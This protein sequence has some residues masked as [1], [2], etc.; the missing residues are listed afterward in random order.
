MGGAKVVHALGAWAAGAGCALHPE[1]CWG[2]GLTALHVA[3][4]LREPEEVAL[5]LTGL[6]PADSPEL[7]AAACCAHGEETPLGLACRMNKRSLLAALAV[8]GV[9]AAGAMLAALQLQD[10]RALQPVRVAAVE[11]GKAAAATKRLLATCAEEEGLQRDEWAKLMSHQPAVDCNCGAAPMDG[12]TASSVL[13]Q[14]PLAAAE[15]DAYS[16]AASAAPLLDSESPA[17]VLLLRTLS[18][19]CSACSSVVLSGKGAGKGKGGH[20]H[21]L[22]GGSTSD[23]EDESGEGEGEGDWGAPLAALH[24]AVASKD[25]A[26]FYLPYHG[27][28]TGELQL[29]GR[30]FKGGSPLWAFR[31]SAVERSFRTWHS[32]ELA[33]LDTTVCLALVLLLCAVSSMAPEELRRPLHLWLLTTVARAPLMLQP[34][35][36]LCAPARAAYRRCRDG[37]LLALHVAVF[38]MQYWWPSQMGSVEWLAGGSVLAS[39]PAGLWL[40]IA[41]FTLQLRFALQ[42]PALLLVYAAN[43]ALLPAA[44]RERLGGVADSLSTC[45]AI[46]GVRLFAISVVLPLL[47]VWMVEARARQAFM[48]MRNSRLRQP[49]L[50]ACL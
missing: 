35:L 45:V 18:G 11:G 10:R 2:G 17:S 40:L 32:G 37:L 34:V 15:P 49:T 24:K 19:C 28:Q 23:S 9:P 6:C 7:W 33:K 21:S 13:N 5:A 14:L 22:S 46:G 43:V 25:A 16:R 44:C 38:A 39:Q 3:T 47:A 12:L 8:H 29:A 26:S 50:S 48:T 42:V 20:K 4:L 41:V 1:A 30:H 31:D 36:L 27:E